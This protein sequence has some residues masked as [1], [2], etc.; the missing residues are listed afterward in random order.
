MF[1]PKQYAIIKS[2]LVWSRLLKI[3]IHKIPHTL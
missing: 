2:A 1:Y 3:N